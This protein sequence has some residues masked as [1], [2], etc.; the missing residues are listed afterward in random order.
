[1]PKSI[2]SFDFSDV[3]P[4]L[5]AFQREV[6]ST[7]DEVGKDAVEYAV[8]NGNY[9]DRTGR[10]RSSNKHKADESGLELTNDAEYASYV[11]AKNGYDV[12]SGAVLH[13]EAKLK[14]IFEK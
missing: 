1:M 14:D 6:I 8:K 11:E 10:L 9:K 2:V 7:V 3:N 13:A 4:A 5:N 12:I